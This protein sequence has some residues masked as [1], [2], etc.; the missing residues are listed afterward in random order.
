MWYVV[1]GMWYV[2]CGVCGMWYVVCGA[3]STYKN[4]V[5]R[6]HKENFIMIKFKLIS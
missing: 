3:C 6:E 1:C 2:V 4:K 5:K